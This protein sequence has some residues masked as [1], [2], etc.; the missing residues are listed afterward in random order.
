M[1]NLFTIDTQDYDPNGSVCS[2]PSVRAI[3]IADHKVLM[4]HSL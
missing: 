4:V 3:I 1:R 2:R